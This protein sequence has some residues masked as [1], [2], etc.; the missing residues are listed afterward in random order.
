MFTFW[1]CTRVLQWSCLKAVSVS[2]FVLGGLR[3]FTATSDIVSF[4]QGPFEAPSRCRRFGYSSV[5][6]GKTLYRT[7]ACK[8]NTCILSVDSFMYVFSIYLLTD[9]RGRH[10]A[11]V[12][13]VFFS[14]T[15]S[16]FAFYNGDQTISRLDDLQVVNC[17]HPLALLP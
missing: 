5:R 2:T 1:I 11:F 4:H 6:P 8:F 3:G 17:Q 10:S 15:N 7:F 16:F 13:A 9:A 12:M 14:F